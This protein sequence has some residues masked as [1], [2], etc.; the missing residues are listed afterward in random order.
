M[1]AKINTWSESEAQQEI[2]RLQI[3]NQAN[4]ELI[5]GLKAQIEGL[6]DMIE[7]DSEQIIE[8][9]RQAA[10]YKSECVGLKKIV[11]TMT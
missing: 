10:Q 2:E 5:A 9:Q 3:T 8:L 7:K 6:T 4:K 11:Q 1:Q